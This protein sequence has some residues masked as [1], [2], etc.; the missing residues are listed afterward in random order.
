[1]D[2]GHSRRDKVEFGFGAVYRL[3]TTIYMSIE[4]G[5]LGRCETERLLI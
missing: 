3:M 5:I 1:M 4:L 2:A